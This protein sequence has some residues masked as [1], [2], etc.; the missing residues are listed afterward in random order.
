MRHALQKLGA[1]PMGMTP[2]L[3]TILSVPVVS[4][5][6]TS[7]D[8]SWLTTFR[9][10]TL[11]HAAAVA[12][13]VAVM[14]A[15]SLAGRAW[16]GTSRGES[17]RR[18]IAAFGIFYWIASNTWWCWPSNFKIEESLPLH[19]CDIAGLVGP[20][21]LLTRWRWLRALLYFW[22]FV[23]S[24]QGFIQPTLEHGARFTRYWL[25]WAN[26]TIIVGTALYDVAALGFRPR[27]RDYRTGVIGT[28]VYVAAILPFNIAFRDQGVNYGYVGNLKPDNPTIIDRLGPWP[29]RLA[30]LALIAFGA[31]AAFWAPWEFVR[32]LDAAKVGPS[33]KGD[34]ES[35]RP[36]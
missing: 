8:G 24:L 31:M 33:G 20:A 5:Q 10:F 6:G 13:C 14:V 17:L 19:V 25:F 30:P 2:F 32:R 23:L 26:H 28:L 9:P 36:S 21:A 15:V 12:I 3:S 22:G 11:H 27:W 4:T 34:G 1:A 18:A 29:W 35:A 7:G 16:R